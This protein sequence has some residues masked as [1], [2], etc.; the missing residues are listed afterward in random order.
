MAVLV[1][2]VILASPVSWPPVVLM[3]A[4][5]CALAIGVYRRLPAS[6]LVA[7]TAVEGEI[8]SS[9]WGDKATAL[10]GTVPFSATREREGARARGHAGGR[11]GSA[12]WF[13]DLTAWRL[14]VN[15]WQTWLFLL[16]LFAYGFL[17][18]E[19]F[20]EGQELLPFV[21]FPAAWAYGVLG[22]SAQRISYLD[23][24]PV[25]R[26]QLFLYPAV[27]ALTVLAL[28]IGTAEIRQAAHPHPPRMINYFDHE[29]HVP[30]E[31]CEIAW[32]GVVPEV[33]SPWGEHYTP[34]GHR[35]LPWSP[36]VVY[37]PFEHGRGNSPEFVAL[38]I[39][40]GIEA[41]HGVPVPA[42]YTE[43]GFRLPDSYVDAIRR[44]A[45][46]VEGSVGRASEGRS[47]TVALGALV[48]LFLLVPIYSVSLAGQSATPRGAVCKWT[49]V[50]I[51]V[52]VLLLITGAVVVQTLGFTKVWAVGALPWILLR[53]LAAALPV[54]TSVLWILFLA[55]AGASYFILVR[56]FERIEA[57]LK[58]KPSGFE[59]EY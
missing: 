38:Q 1:L 35:V 19:K 43:P 14:L 17:L 37:D 12:R 5:A 24:L 56:V 49:S 23:P 53:H 7:D 33:T 3:L 20:Y 26:R 30:E 2:L 25:S 58:A 4:A 18:A 32:D 31:F 15:Q 22:T 11:V 47:R 16:G 42:R 39:D 27:T 59:Q 52:A 13:R 34:E 6:L 10:K 28:G 44:G 45:F 21:L 46:T 51:L 29:M 50:G 36:A 57:P 40:R 55:A 54:G 8:A 41:V 48:F 9:R